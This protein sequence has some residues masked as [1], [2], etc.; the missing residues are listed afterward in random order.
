MFGACWGPQ[1]R[2]AMICTAQI[3]VAIKGSREGLEE[4]GQTFDNVINRAF[5][6]EQRWQ[7]PQADRCVRH[8]V[9]PRRRERT[10]GGKGGL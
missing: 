10:L 4:E 9:G 2:Q 8:H 1:R 5:P 6:R 3:L 7:W